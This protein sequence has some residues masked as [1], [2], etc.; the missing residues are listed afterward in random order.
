[1]LLDPT[2]LEPA[3][4]A[5]LESIN[6]GFVFYDRN[7]LVRYWN[8][9]AEEL[10]GM[11]RAEVLGRNIWS[12]FPEEV[13]QLFYQRYNRALERQQP[14]S[15]EGY[16]G[17]TGSWFEVHAYPSAAGLAIFF[18]DV[19]VQHRREQELRETRARFELVLR[20]TNEA[21]CDVDLVAHTAFWPG[22][23]YRRLFGHEVPAAP[24]SENSWLDHVHPDDLPGVLA[25]YRQAVAD[26]SDG[27]T[28]RYRFRR[29]DGSIAFVRGRSLLLRDGSGTVTRVIAA[30]EDVSGEQEVLRML[31]RRAQEFR[32]IF[33]NAPMPQWIFDRNTLRVL[34]VNTAALEEYGYTRDEFM[35]LTVVDLR[36]TEDRAAFYDIAAQCSGDKRVW[37]PVRHLRADGSILEVQLQATPIHYEGHAATAVTVNDITSYRAAKQALQR[38]QEDYKRLFNSAPLPQCI[39]SADARR[40]LEVNDAA[41]ALYGYSRAELLAMT[42]FDLSLPE[43]HAPLRE[44][45]RLLQRIGSIQSVTRHRTRDG[46]IILV[47][48]S[49]THATYNGETCLLVTLNDITYERQLEENITALKVSAQKMITRAQLNA[50]EEER[51]EIGREL[52]D[53]INQQL[54][55]IKLYV[56]MARSR[57]DLSPGLLEKSEALLQGAIDGIRALSRNLVQPHFGDEGLAPALADLCAT[58]EATAGFRLHLDADT[59]VAD[60]ELSLTIYR[61]V[62]EAL[63]N[64]SRYAGARNVWVTLAE[65]PDALCLTVRD[66]G[67]GFDPAVRGAGI[68]LT[69]MSRRVDLFNGRLDVTAAP[70]AG[71]TV[72]A[73][74]PHAARSGEGLYV[75]IAED[76]ADDRDVL[77]AAF[78]SL[79]PQCRLHFSGNGMELLEHLRR[80]P[81]E[82][83]HL[84]VID[85]NMPL[86]NGVDTLQALSL[87]PRFRR[88]PKVLYSTTI[89]AEDRRGAYATAYIEKALDLPGI[90]SNVQQ[91]LLLVRGRK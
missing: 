29:A 62:Q 89:R 43:D 27:F 72:T 8:G 38:S 56:A 83:P 68:G 17:R 12:C 80:H 14:D 55:S 45:I 5:I 30:L 3:T 44:G 57:A 37:S 67:R 76:D 7:S 52:H 1:M 42:P 63:T 49:A 26:G 61:V 16:L 46:A 59:P 15:F 34:A 85:Q 23:N 31:E 10:L 36:P 48:L 70:G 47:E 82:V 73:L 25:T 60:P 74:L 64:V 87:D 54:T 19:T 20:A 51:A 78:R 58:F 69:N 77:E 84:V 32:L 24:A 88:V 81:G 22:D 86:L 28:A 71:C 53:N 90:R 91:M 41:I 9:R 13:G 6:D 66:D 65:T 75:A 50:Q 21:I 33:D 4:A 35:N 18:R 79:L 39:C 2:T 40:I 11:P